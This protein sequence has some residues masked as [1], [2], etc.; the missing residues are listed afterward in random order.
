[1]ELCTPRDDI[2]IVRQIKEH[3]KIGMM[4]VWN[5]YVKFQKF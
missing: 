5:S 2:P 4:T 3:D 1:V